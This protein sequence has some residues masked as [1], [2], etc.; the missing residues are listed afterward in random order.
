MIP[1]QHNPL[2]ISWKQKTK[3]KNL[4][5]Y[6]TI[7]YILDLLLMIITIDEN[8]SY[9]YSEACNI[10]WNTLQQQS[11]PQQ[12]HL[13]LH[14]SSSSYSMLLTQLFQSFQLIYNVNEIIYQK[15]Q[16]KFIDLLLMLYH[17]Y[18]Y[19]W[20]INTTTI[21]I[22]M[23]DYIDNF[24]T[25]I[26]TKKPAEVNIVYLSKVYTLLM[27]ITANN[28]E[29]MFMLAQY[30][31]TYII[32]INELHILI[33]IK[34]IQDQANTNFIQLL[35]HKFYHQLHIYQ[36]IM[37]YIISNL[38]LSNDKATITL[39]QL[40]SQLCINNSE[41]A[42]LAIDLGLISIL[43]KMEHKT[44]SSHIGPEIETLLNIFK[45][46]N[47]KVK[48]HLLELR[49]LAKAKK[50]R[51]ALNKRK[52]ILK[53]LQLQQ[54]INSLS[55]HLP[56]EELDLKCLVCHEGYSIN[57]SSL[58]AIYCYNDEIKTFSNDQ[59]S[60]Y[61]KNLKFIGITNENIGMI[62]QYQLGLAQSN[63]YRLHTV[64]NFHIIHIDCHREAMY[65]DEEL[66]PAKSEWEGATIRNSH[67]LCNNLLPIYHPKLL[68]EYKSA[69]TL[70]RNRQKSRCTKFN[71]YK[72]TSSLISPYLNDIISCI[73][74]ICCEQSLA[75]KTQGG[76]K[77][78]NLKF[79]IFLYQNLSI[80][81]LDIPNN[82]FQLLKKEIDDYLQC[83]SSIK[84]VQTMYIDSHSSLIRLL[85]HKLYQPDQQSNDNQVLADDETNHINHIYLY[86]DEIYILC[87]CISFIYPTIT[88]WISYRSDIINLLQLYIKE[89]IDHDANIYRQCILLIY[90]MDHIYLQ[91]LNHKQAIR[92]SKKDTQLWGEQDIY[93]NF[94]Q[95]QQ[96]TN[97]NQMFQLLNTLWQ[98]SINTINQ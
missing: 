28:T 46:S 51:K 1:N 31:A 88:E 54:N 39:I 74:Q 55:Q 45:T 35:K 6:D 65:A 11:S 62:N 42:N 98:S 13:H 9:I 93:Q 53:S 49:Q 66:S 5:I 75:I 18:Y 69:L 82:I 22:N 8:K 7:F 90:L 4:Y 44:S 96:C 84:Q 71:S 79:F 19:K 33:L 47:N 81:L 2:Q 34:M 30:F 89:L 38:N 87:I 92:L 12:Q 27:Y 86:L 17:D 3:A 52:K 40:L 72:F 56:Q 41:A 50:K 37:N 24:I 23:K 58:L 77:S 68:N 14:L 80:L 85:Y 67:T 32:S 97:Q 15:L 26:I 21:T 70:Y 61:L 25:V 36:F 57:T 95:L 73:K 64:S 76:E 94:I 48:E 59:I 91:Q 20:L 29:S 16:S 63:E 43:H 60:N 78:S 83:I 10:Y